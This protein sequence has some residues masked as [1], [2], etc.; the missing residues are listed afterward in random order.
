[1]KAK[2]L[3]NVLNPYGPD[4]KSLFLYSYKAM[5]AQDYFLMED[6]WLRHLQYVERNVIGPPKATK[7]YTEDE[8][9]K[10]GYVGLYEG[11]V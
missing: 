7:R 2:H 9:R 3:G 5:I 4:A 1:M 8:L 6:E 11:K 10:M